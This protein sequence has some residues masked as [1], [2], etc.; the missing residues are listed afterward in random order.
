LR[1]IVAV[2]TRSI[3]REIVIDGAERVKAQRL[4]KEI[5]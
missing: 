1:V 3:L 5:N 4:R 2:Q